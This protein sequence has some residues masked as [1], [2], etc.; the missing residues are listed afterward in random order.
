MGHPDF[1]ANG[2][3]F[4]TLSADGHRGMVT[5]TPPQQKAFMNGDHETFEPA[6]GAWGRQGCTMVVLAE[7]DEETVG[8]AMTLAWRNTTTVTP[9]AAKKRARTASQ[10]ARRR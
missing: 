8:E 5:L 10:P 9:R 6:S 7:A 3:I 2:R 1:R 4:A